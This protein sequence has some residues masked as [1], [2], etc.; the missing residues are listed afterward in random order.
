[1][2][3]CL[4][5]WEKWQW[6]EGGGGV[7]GCGGGGQGRY[8]MNNFLS[9]WGCEWHC[10]SIGQT[11]CRA[12]ARSWDLLLCPCVCVCVCV[13]HSFHEIVYLPVPSP[14]MSAADAMLLPNGRMM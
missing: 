1:M 14:W 12:S 10:C 5:V 6:E 8:H 9:M 13:C 4:S 2:T 7:G 3:A 11:D